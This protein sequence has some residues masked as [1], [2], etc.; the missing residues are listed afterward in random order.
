MSSTATPHERAGRLADPAHTL[1]LVDISSFIF[2][3]YYAIRP[4]HTK[5]KEP[6]NAVYGVAQMLSRL[7]DEARPEYLAVVY[8]SK[9]PSFRKEIFPEYKANRSAA[10]DDLIPQ[11]ARIEQLIQVFEM[12]SYRQS[13]VEADDLIATLT[14]RWTALS[15]KNKVVIVSSDK[16][17]MQL[18][19]DRVSIWDTMKNVIFG[20]PE[21]EE[22]FGVRPN[23]IR[24][25]L[26][27]VGDSSDNIPGVPSIGPKSAVDLLKAHQTLDA[28]LKAAAEGKISGK[29]GEVLVKHEEDAR[30]SAELATVHEEL[31]IE[32]VPEKMKYRF[33][34]TQACAKLLAELDFHTLLNRWTAE[35]KSYLSAPHHD[36]SHAPPSLDQVGDEAGGPSPGDMPMD[37][38]PLPRISAI[39]DPSQFKTI[40]T[41]EALETLLKEI[42]NKKQFGFDVETTSLNPR[43]AELVGI[44]ICV[45]PSYSTYIPVGHRG[46]EV[47]QLELDYVLK[48]LKP[49]LE[50]PRYK[51][52]GQNLKYDWSVLRQFGIEP[53]GIGADTMVAAYVLDPEGRHNLETLSAHYLNYTVTTYEQVCGKG[54]DQLCFDQVP[55]DQATRYSAEDAWVAVK[56]WEQLEPKLRDENLTEVFARVDLPLVDVLSRMESQGVCIDVDYLKTLSKEFEKDLHSIE[57]KIAE[58]TQGPINLNSPKQLGQLLFEELKLPVQGKTKTGYSTDAQVLGVL[59]E[60]HEVP[61]LLLEYREISKLKGTYVDPLPL[62][63]DAKTGK[64][65][66]S[67]HQTVA[68]TGR[69]SSSDPNLQNI[70]IRS[71]R[72]LKIRRAFIPCPGNKLVSADYSQIELRLLAHMSGDPELV[73]SFQKD[74]DVHRRTASEIFRVKPDQVSDRQRSIAK[75]INFG[76]MYGKTAFGLS[77]ELKIPRKE[78][79][80]IIQ[81]YFERYSAV[82]KFLD[83]Q[84]EEARE[85]GY[86]C[87][88]LGR[89][90][91][92]PD[93]G[94]RNAAIRAN[95]ERMAMNTPIQGTAAD[96]MK[97]AMTQIDHELTG[98]KMKSKLIIQVHDEV[99][100]D[101]PPDE[102]E[103]ARQLITEVMESA[104]KLDVPLRV[105]SASGDSWFDL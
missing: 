48:K 14:R 95:A 72:G 44:A 94:A 49:Y 36:D 104:M 86:V 103:K 39:I 34:I 83:G 46:T 35:N 75:A 2:R 33:H 61:R 37:M 90:R 20:P 29:K 43:Q 67:F 91:H 73:N 96:L 54:K 18:V 19:N 101:C 105:N 42:E 71:E 13:G 26:A 99:V 59:S 97:I 10:P 81:R 78:A 6:V 7:A 28:V 60:Y 64:I 8:D 40:N 68:A 93:I 25:Y 89:K 100:L 24:D 66:A 32:V 15:E 23:Q 47:P 4:L 30:L 76:L 77:Q 21:V 92:L 53:D 22:K 102:V 87:T 31:T 1:Y 63:R 88:L 55:I 41:K 85:R 45:D 56:L 11:F 50:D 80:D 16:D 98:R 38:A 58:Y 69:L 65:H 3:A 84:I 62:M 70:P 12:H 5:H 17:L 52:I 82:K 27:L 74:E 51:K 57:R 79:A 9:E